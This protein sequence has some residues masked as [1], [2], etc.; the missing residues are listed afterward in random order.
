MERGS[1][2]TSEKGYVLVLEPNHPEAD[3]AGYVYEHRVLMEQYL[4]E[5][6]RP[7]E[8]VH[9]RDRRRWNNDFDNLLLCLN[10]DIHKSIHRAMQSRNLRLVEEYERWMRRLAQ[11]RAN[12]NGNGRR[13]PEVR[14]PT[15]PNASPSARLEAPT[16]EAPLADVAHPPVLDGRAL[17]NDAPVE[18]IDAICTIPNKSERWIYLREILPTVA[19]PALA[20]GM[21]RRINVADPERTNR[22]IWLLGELDIEEAGSAF[23][24]VLRY[25]KAARSLRTSVYSAL[26]KRRY[27]SLDTDFLASVSVEERGQPLL[28]AVAAVAIQCPSEKAIAAIEAIAGVADPKYDRA[29]LNRSVRSALR[30][31]QAHE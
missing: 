30:K 17:A 29:A 5:P 26:K 10:G 4:G 2:K 15:Q 9:H 3:R 7:G 20:A 31:L 1:K 16:M 23:I 18:V 14:P 12:N 13:Y 24:S 6:L 21:I 11:D 27:A 28:Y 22:L 25:P 8:I 19:L